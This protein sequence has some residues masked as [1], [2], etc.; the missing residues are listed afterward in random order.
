MVW[1][2]VLEVGVVE[3]AVFEDKAVAD[4]KVI[5]DV[6]VL[7]ERG[8]EGKRF[9]RGPRRIE[10]WLSGGEEEKRRQFGVLRVQ[11]R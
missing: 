1:I 2:G 8:D 9:P 5:L 6:V 4:N 7:R 10:R 11:Q 3:N